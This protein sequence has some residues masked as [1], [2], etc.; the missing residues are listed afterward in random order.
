MPPDKTDFERWLAAQFADTGSFTIF[1]VLVR[2]VG[3]EVQAVRSSYAQ[4]VG[5][6]MPWLQMRRLLDGAHAVW[7]GVAFFVGLLDE[8][9]GPMPDTMA[10]VKLGEVEAQVLADPLVL[11]RGL[12]FDREGRHMR[13]DEVTRAPT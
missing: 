7:D 11:N 2:I 5:D 13:I 1:I 12:F 10:K 6:D 9:G 4:M 3:N 8:S